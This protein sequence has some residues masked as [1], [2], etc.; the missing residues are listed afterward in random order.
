MPR[1][2]APSAP[3]PAAPAGPRP[4]ERRR[5]LPPLAALRRQV[6]RLEAP[7][8]LRLL[9]RTLRSYGAHA[10]GIYAGALAFFGVLSL[11]PLLLLLIALLTLLVQRADATA[12]VLSRVTAFF[13]GSASTIVGAIDAVTAAQ[14][15]LLGVGT[16]G[17][18]WSSMGVFL[19]LGYALNRIWE[20]PRDRPILVQYAIAAGLALSVGLLVLCSALLSTV[21]VVLHALATVL[22]HQGI[23]GLG[24]VAVV[25]ANALDVVVV[26]GVATVLYRVLPNALVRWREALP[27]AVLV[28]L[29]WEAA[30]LGFTWYLATVAHVDRLYGPVAAIAGLL[31][32]LFVSAILLLLGAELSHQLARSRTPGSQLE[33]GRDT[34]SAGRRRAGAAGTDG[35]PSARRGPDDGRQAG[36]A[37]AAPGRGGPARGRTV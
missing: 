1:S 14:P 16:L 27:P 31:L 13:P 2:G 26:A 36:R 30:K 34:G 37:P 4:R 29:L 32:W 20:A 6:G 15:V 25:G 22:R 18:L 3:T 12:L 35:A 8:P 23:P 17:L 5:S 11:F 24:T 10:C 21:V 7:P 33:G 28:A 19:T 9:W